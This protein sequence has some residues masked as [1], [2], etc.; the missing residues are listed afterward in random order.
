MH[1]ANRNKLDNS[2][3]NLEI[4]TPAI[5]GTRHNKLWRSASHKQCGYCGTIKA[6]SQFFLHR[7]KT[8]S[9]LWDTH[10]TRC[11]RCHKAPKTCAA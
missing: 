3:E 4:V 5:H 8:R 10:H 11:K 9:P 7:K 6:R 2:P 1:H